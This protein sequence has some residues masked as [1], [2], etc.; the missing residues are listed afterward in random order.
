MKRLQFMLVND[1]N[2]SLNIS[3]ETKLLYIMQKD[4]SQSV[5]F[6]E[7]EFLSQARKL[8]PGSLRKSGIKEGSQSPKYNIYSAGRK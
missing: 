5:L 1:L 4:V 8:L 2:V 3:A 7:R 6:L